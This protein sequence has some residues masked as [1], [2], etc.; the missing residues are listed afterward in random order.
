MQNS[1]RYRFWGQ[2]LQKRACR[3][4]KDRVLCLQRKPIF[5]TLSRLKSVPVHIVP[6]SGTQKI[7]EKKTEP[8]DFKGI[9]RFGVLDNILGRLAATF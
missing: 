3:F 9:S 5:A 4:Q 1:K 8:D 2:A 6:R 7:I